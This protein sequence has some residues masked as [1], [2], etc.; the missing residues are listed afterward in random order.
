MLPVLLDL[1]FFKIY[2]YGIFL[3]LAFFW[4]AF[5]LWKNITLTPYKEEEVFDGLFFSLFGSFITGRVVYII[6]HSSDFG[7]NIGKMIFVNGYP[8]INGVG[9]LFGLL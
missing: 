6:L 5:F 4:G 9:I 8:G 3:M 2:T 7:F 1:G